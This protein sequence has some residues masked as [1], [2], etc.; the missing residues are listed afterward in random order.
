MIRRWRADG[1]VESKKIPLAP[2]PEGAKSGAAV[3]VE[4]PAAFTSFI[5]VPPLY[6][7]ARLIVHYC[8]DLPTGVATLY[9]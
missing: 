5:F 8:T 6:L 4:V 1:E 2:S 7:V 3:N 9:K